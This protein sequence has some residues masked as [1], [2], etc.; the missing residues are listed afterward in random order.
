M[1][2][3]RGRTKEKSR[4]Q[5]AKSQSLP[6]A[7]CRVTAGTRGK[8]HLDQPH[9]RTL[10]LAFER[11]PVACLV[12]SSLG[13]VWASMLPL[14]GHSLRRQLTTLFL[15]SQFK[16]PKEYNWPEKKLKVSILPDVVFDSPLH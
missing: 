15:S 13:T 9:V 5:Y 4:R 8:E 10:S 3:A 1:I 11:S 6:S 12:P 14:S 2:L 7:A 16:L